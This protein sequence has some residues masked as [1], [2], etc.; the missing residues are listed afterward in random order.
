MS[1]STTFER[2]SSDRVY[3]WPRGRLEVREEARVFGV[4]LA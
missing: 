3:V 2:R 4:A 1:V